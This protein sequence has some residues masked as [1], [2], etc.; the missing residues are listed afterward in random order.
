MRR[1]EF[2]ALA[3]GAAAWPAAARAQEANLP[4]I[5]FVSNSKLESYPESSLAAFHRG[6]G[7][8]GYVDGQNVAVDY[9]VAD[10]QSDRL[11]ALVAELVRRR[12]AVIVTANSLPPANAAKAATTTIPIVFLMGADP[13]ENNL[14]ASLARP[15]GNVTGVTVIAG[16]LFEKRLGL[17]HELVP[18]A[19]LIGYFVNRGIQ[20][21]PSS[22][23]RYHLLHAL[24]GLKC[25][26]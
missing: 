4:T 23:G 20:P 5:G 6:L 18:A 22:H 26:N 25:W 21:L 9:R 8:T 13:V 24:L 12:V 2:I 17:L 1:R 11:P 15:G 7:E 10:D 14:V 19:G 16:D 3:G